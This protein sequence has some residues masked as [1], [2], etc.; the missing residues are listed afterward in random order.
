LIVTFGGFPAGARPSAC[1]ITALRERIV[2]REQ[3]AGLALHPPLSCT[4]I[5]G[6]V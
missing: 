3:R 5:F 1:V 6:I 2:R 4:S